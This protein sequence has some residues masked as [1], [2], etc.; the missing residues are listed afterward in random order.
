MDGLYGRWAVF[1]TEKHTREQTSSAIQGLIKRVYTEWLPT[2]SFQKVDGY[3]LE[4]YFDTDDG[5][6]YCETWIRVI[7]M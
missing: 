1:K 7:P 5:M 2:A 3:E 6:Y 4:L